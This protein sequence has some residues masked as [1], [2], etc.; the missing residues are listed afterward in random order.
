MSATTEHEAEP[1]VELS[2][3]E[4][5]A[6]AD[7][8]ASYLRAVPPGRE[9]PYH[10]LLDA[11]RAGVVTGDGV[12]VLQQVCA[13]ALETGEARRVGLA[14][15][16][17]LLT[18]VY[19]RTPDGRARLAEIKQLNEALRHLTDK[20]LRTAR[21]SWSR[22]GRHTLT[23]GVDGFDLTIAFERGGVEISSLSTS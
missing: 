18:G 3:E 2:A 16:E 7:V 8:V 9:Q 22:P 23:V 12:S 17:T 21:V 20:R 4:A 14:E 10:D 15:V 1:R 11:A 19:R 6:L 13:L 5:S